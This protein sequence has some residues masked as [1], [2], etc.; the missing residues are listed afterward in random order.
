MKNTNLKPFRATHPPLFAL[1]SLLF[2]LSSPL[3]ALCQK[4]LQGEIGWLTSWSTPSKKS[5]CNRCKV[6]TH[7]FHLPSMKPHPTN[8][9]TY[10]RFLA[11]LKSEKLWV[12]TKARTLPTQLSITQNPSA[13]RSLPFAKKPFR[14]RSDGWPPGQPL[15]KNHDAIGARFWLTIF[16]CL[17]WNHTP[18]IFSLTTAF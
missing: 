2:A 5:R 13:L 7:N 3:S 18:R 12:K 17:Q 10:N 15:L 6:L 4:A 16:T 1:S 11:N 8:F 14:A 9:F